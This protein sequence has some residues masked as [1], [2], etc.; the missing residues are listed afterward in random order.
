MKKLFVS[1]ENEFSIFISRL[2][3]FTCGG[4]I[5]LGIR[6]NFF[7]LNIHAYIQLYIQWKVYRP[8]ECKDEEEKKR[9]IFFGWRK[10]K[11][12]SQS[13]QGTI[14]IS[15]KKYWKKLQQLIKTKLNCKLYTSWSVILLY[16]HCNKWSETK[17]S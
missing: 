12:S 10:R 11:N 17:K 2:R 7:F 1:S 14:V 6:K 13:F 8:T 15:V 4:L 3:Y 5:V 16:F 9:M